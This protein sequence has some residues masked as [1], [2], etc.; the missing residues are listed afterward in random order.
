[1]AKDKTACEVSKANLNKLSRHEL[2]HTLELSKKDNFIQLKIKVFRCHLVGQPGDRL[3]IATV[4]YDAS[5]GY[6]ISIING[7]RNITVLVNPA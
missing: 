2:F 3:Y 4:H 7:E 1:M 6:S 5:V